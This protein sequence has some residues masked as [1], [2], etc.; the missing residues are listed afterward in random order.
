MTGEPLTTVPR[1]GSPTQLAAEKSRREIQQGEDERIGALKAYETEVN[2]IVSNI[3]SLISD[4]NLA[5]VTGLI[6]GR[7]PQFAMTEAMIGV[8]ASIN[9]VIGQTFMQAYEKLKGG[10]VITEI[11]GEK[12]T[13]SLNKLQ[14]Q[15][16]STQEYIKELVRFRA[17]VLEL[18]EVARQRAGQAQTMI[19]P[20]GIPIRQVGQ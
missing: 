19:T 11:E 13:N 6:G 8:Q 1:Q 10:G 12:A 17:A 4:P 2:E 18:Q 9:R 5:S 20:G 14:T 7:I 16:M 15:A 3:D